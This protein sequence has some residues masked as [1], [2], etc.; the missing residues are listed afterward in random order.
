MK[1]KPLQ[2]STQAPPTL[3]DRVAIGSFSGLCTLGLGSAI[4]FM[5][6]SRWGL[7][8][9]PFRPVLYGSAAI[10]V[11]GFFLA[12]NVVITVI[13][14]LLSLFFGIGQL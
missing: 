12:E 14:A 2:R 7:A 8:P 11:L 5:L 9:L 6:S 10:A 13:G 1:R 3:L 4:W